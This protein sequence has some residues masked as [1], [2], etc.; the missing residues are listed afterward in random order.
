[1]LLI[2]LFIGIS[3]VSAQWEVKV[4]KQ[5]FMVYLYNNDFYVVCKG[6]DANFDGQYDPQTDELPSL[7]RNNPLGMGPISAYKLIDLP[8]GLNS[9]PVRPYFENEFLYIQT[10][11]YIWKYNI[12]EG[13]LIDSIEFTSTVNG[14]TINDN[15]LYV[16]T[17][18]TPPG[19]W[20]PEN[21]YIIR[22]D[23]QTKQPM[24]TI[25]A[26]MNVQ[27]CK[28][29]NNMLYVLNEGTGA[30]NESFVSVYDLNTKEE[31]K[32]FNAGIFGNYFEIK[33]D[34]IYIVSNGSH[35]VFKYS[36][37]GEESLVYEVG[38]SG[39]DGPR[40]IVFSP[41]GNKFRVSAYDGNIYEFNLI[42]TTPVLQINAVKKVE[43][44]LWT[45]F[46]DNDVFIAS[47]INNQDYSAN[48]Y[49]LVWVNPIS[50]VADLAKKVVVYPN[51]ATDYV[52]ISNSENYFDK[53]ELVSIDGKIL[54]NGQINGSQERISLENMNS[55]G[56]L[57]KLSGS[58]QNISI[59]LKI[60][61]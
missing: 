54:L 12:E 14:L 7:W 18:V 23:L 15:I 35:K 39:W 36:L 13:N 16:T 46:F 60:I 43:G 45:N 17:R 3:N 31:I 50:T 37:N 47:L 28:V 56:Y 27:M 24:D 42:S 57:L 41:D 29:H 6:V 53:Y 40:E 34:Y 1:M 44:M 11:G 30:D 59:P 38:T 4:G 22:I 2:A 48:D 26:K 52:L 25:E 8:F 33:D 19:S 61:K 20:T 32:S 9:F 49:V 21:N 58:K 51:P 10:N 5:P 55:G